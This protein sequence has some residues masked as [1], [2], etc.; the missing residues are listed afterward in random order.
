MSN[1]VTFETARALK[2]AGF[3]QPEEMQ[4]GQAWYD[5][6]GIGHIPKKPDGMMQYAKQRGWIFAP[7]AT[8]ILQ[9]LGQ[10]YVLWFDESPRLRQFYCAR[11][12][13]T[14]REAGTPFGNPNPHEAAALAYLNL[15][16]PLAP[17]Q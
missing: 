10:N 7:T 4:R 17:K 9:A 3:P 16:K 13:N 8:D 5:R 1:T 12:G 15:K 14:T 6:K 11:T 2:E